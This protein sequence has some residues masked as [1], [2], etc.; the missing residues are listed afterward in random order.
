MQ[1]ARYHRLAITLHWVMALAILLM[2]TSGLLMTER[3]LLE[4][5]LR[6]SMYQWHKSLGVLVLLALA[7]R[8]V[9]RLRF[10]P[11]PLPASM[12]PIEKKA[13]HAGHFA[14]YALML[15]MPLSGWAIVSSS[16]FGLPT[17]VFGLFEWPHM[18]GIAGNEQAHEAAEE[19]HEILA[20]VLMAFI[21]GH[22][23]AVIK[24]YVFEKENLLPRM[25]I[26]KVKDDA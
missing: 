19:A 10:A 14:L 7:L 6:F 24:H 18:P 20:W 16:S 4:K 5:T 23:G 15:I 26:G 3:D 21:A 2:L 8:I 11:P 1:P 12:K 22:I 17:L 9:I 25:G 13:A